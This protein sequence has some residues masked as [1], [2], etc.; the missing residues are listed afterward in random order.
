MEIMQKNKNF[1]KHTEFLKTNAKFE[2]KSC[3]RG[4]YPQA[5]LMD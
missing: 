2:Q 5:Q 3:E 4:I 1:A